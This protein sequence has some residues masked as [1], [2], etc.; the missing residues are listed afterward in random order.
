MCCV[1]SP[2]L[3]MLCN[4]FLSTRMLII[5]LVKMVFTVACAA[6]FIT[7]CF[8]WQPGLKI[9]INIWLHDEVAIKNRM[10]YY[11]VYHISF[12]LWSRRKFE[13]YNIVVT[14]VLGQHEET[15]IVWKRKKEDKFQVHW[16]YLLG[17]FDTSFDKKIYRAT[18]SFIP[19]SMSFTI[20]ESNKRYD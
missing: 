16:I 5:Q 9:W 18:I 10:F 8:A 2:I 17:L 4:I 14:N 6:C 15:I 20:Y 3:L 1:P 19:K 13:T 12:W 7:L 11:Y